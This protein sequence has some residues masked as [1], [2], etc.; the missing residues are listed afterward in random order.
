M[1]FMIIFKWNINW[2]SKSDPP[3]IITTLINMG[4]FK[5]VKDSTLW[6]G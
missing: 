3:S 1:N 5:G 2:S 4:L 6:E